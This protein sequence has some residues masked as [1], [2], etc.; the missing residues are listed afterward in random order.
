MAE[1]REQKGEALGRNNP[2][3][4][5]VQSIA[6]NSWQHGALYDPQVRGAWT[7]GESQNQPNI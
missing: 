6:K 2:F 7:E 3:H 5:G 1:K 4:V